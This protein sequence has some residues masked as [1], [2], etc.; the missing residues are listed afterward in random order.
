VVKHD[1][2]DSFTKLVELND[3][4]I[5]DNIPDTLA[6]AQTETSPHQAVSEQ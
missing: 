5:S 2:F 4:E 6:G 1:S 3:I